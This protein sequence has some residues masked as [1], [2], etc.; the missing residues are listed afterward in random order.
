M[1]S[2]RSQWL[3]PYGIVAMRSGLIPR[4]AC[5]LLMMA[6]YGYLA[7]SFTALFLPR[8]VHI[9]SPLATALEFGELPIV[10]WLI[11]GVSARS[12]DPSTLSVNEPARAAG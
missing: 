2:T 12:S 8:L 1:D 9:V 10:V 3:F 7:S 5:V 4:A 11:W 6:G